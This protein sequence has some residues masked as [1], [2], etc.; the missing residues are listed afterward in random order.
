MPPPAASSS[1]TAPGLLPAW[2]VPTVGGLD[3]I[4]LLALVVVIG[5]NPGEL[6][7]AAWA[8]IAAPLLL[9]PALLLLA[10][11]RAPDDPAVDAGEPTRSGRRKRVGRDAAR[12]NARFFLA[13]YGLFVIV[14]YVFAVGLATRLTDELPAL[15]TVVVILPRAVLIALPGAV[16]DL[17]DLQRNRFHRLAERSNHIIANAYL[18]MMPLHITIVFLLIADD[19]FDTFA[20]APW[21]AVGVALATALGTW[22]T[23]TPY[24]L[25]DPAPTSNPV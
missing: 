2:L 9:V 25:E 7:L 20:L 15:A 14:L 12:S 13:H 19:Q 23:D 22:L 6:L 4:V 5:A 8:Q 11:R 16:A 18:R 21:M 17:R 10:A 3:A 24:E 1:P